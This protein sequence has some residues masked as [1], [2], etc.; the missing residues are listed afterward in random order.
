MQLGLLW[1]SRNRQL[2]LSGQRLELRHQISHLSDDLVRGLQ[3]GDHLLLGNHLCAALDHHDGV[4]GACDSQIEAGL[5]QLGVRRIDHLPRADQTHAHRAQALVKGDIRDRQRGESAD[6]RGNVGVVMLVRRKHGHHDLGLVI[7]AF[8]EKGPHGAVYQTGGQR[9]LFRR[10]RLTLEE[11]ARDL[12]GGVV[13]LAVVHGQREEINPFPG[14]GIHYR[15][16]QHHRVAIANGDGPIGL[17][18]HQAGFDH[19]VS[20]GDLLFNGNSHQCNSVR[21]PG[22]KHRPEP[23]LRNGDCEPLREGFIGPILRRPRPCC[24]DGFSKVRARGKQE[25]FKKPH[26]GLGSLLGRIW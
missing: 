4:F 20:S 15:A 24:W 9:L 11:P 16:G 5:L 12:P 26:G 23:P 21:H 7:E 8:G 1:G 17:F 22:R 25:G 6:H 18:G 13:F 3:R 14:F 2:G 19:Q 10:T